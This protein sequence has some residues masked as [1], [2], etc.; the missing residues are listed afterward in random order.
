MLRANRLHRHSSHGRLLFVLPALFLALSACEPEAP[1]PE[2]PDPEAHIDRL[3]SIDER[4]RK[5]AVEQLAAMGNQ[6]VP[7]LIV[8][9][10]S[11]YTQVR[12]EVAHLLGRSRDPRAV[13]IL[14]QALGDQS[15]NVAQTA[16]WA[17]GS[18]RSP[19]AVPA[20]LAY[21]ADV[22]P[23][24]RHQVAWALGA[25]HGDSLTPAL[26]DS[27]HRAVLQALTDPRAE[28][29]QGALLG[30]RELGLRGAVDQVIELATDDSP[31][32]RYL[33]V[34][35]LEQ[36]QNGGYRQTVGDLPEATRAGIVDALI[37]LLD[38][39]DHAS[40][41]TP[42]IRAL[43]RSRDERAVAPLMRLR[44]SGAQEDRAGAAQALTWLQN[45]LAEPE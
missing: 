39:T 26:A 44:D 37:G 18:I 16:A 21:T 38:D 36:L 32:V 6:I 45:S 22:S 20:L 12:F 34:Q 10:S 43:G 9:M 30:I 2:A 25:C 19:A 4:N 24:V 28:V 41:R 1:D 8:E 14:I 40:I 27:A 35:L 31:E 29:R 42:A 23:G 7:R 13:P 3:K 15:A 5:P 33:V 17:L 11:S